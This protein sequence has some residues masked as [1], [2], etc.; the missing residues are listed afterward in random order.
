MNL[1]NLRLASK[2]WLSTLLIVLG[3]SL[4]VGYT[5]VRTS[6]DR[7]ESTAVL[8]TFNAR[9]K[10]TIRWAGLT[11]ANAARSQ[12]V[13]LSS[14]PAVE[15]GLKDAIAATS[16]EIGQMQKAIEAENLT[17]TDRSQLETVANNRKRVLETRAL[18][19]KQRAAGQAEEASSIIT[20]QYLPAMEA[21]QKSQRDFVAMQEQNYETTRTN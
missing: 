15:L 9:V 5:A 6:S 8:D 14:D 17:A 4:V 7:M 3:I 1:Q 20:S 19:M 21:Y 12:A 11:Q 10:M 18:A 2:L 13:L 16:A